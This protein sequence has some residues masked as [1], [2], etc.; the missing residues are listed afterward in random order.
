MLRSKMHRWRV[1]SLAVA[2]SCL[3]AANLA[4]QRRQRSFSL[5]ADSPEFW[6][7][8]A[9]DAQLVT[10]GS[11]FGFTEGPIWEPGGTLIVS[12]EV[13]NELCR[14][15]PD[16]HHETIMKLGDPDGNTL[17]QQRRVIV[18]ASVLRSLIRLSP[19]EKSYT[20]I[21]DRYQ[22]MRLN[23]PNDVTLGP[24][25][26]LYFTDP[27]LDL[28]KGEKQET[29]WKGVY[30]LASDGTLTLLVRDLSQPNGLA[31]SPDG[32]YLFVDD[33]ERK[34]I[35]RYTFHKEG[36]V[37]DGVLFAEEK[38]TDAPGVPDG[39]KFDRKGNLY[40]TGPG[41]I[42]VWSPEGKRLGRILLPT[43]AANLTWGGEDRSTM[44]ITAG[45]KVYTLKM[46]VAGYLPYAE[47]KEKK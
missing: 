46:K 36:T 7:L 2:L 20:V 8:V 18:T 37:S 3:A 24:D 17:D 43:T 39:M 47:P 42:W 34:E 9:K 10:V 25:G 38:S 6:S 21:A 5:E 26:A 19:D 30:R 12:D 23:S 16:G 11:G 14:L 35:W 28:V 45:P 32:R 15:Y 33:T 4:A 1:V 13:T 31:F 27:T 44:W 22:G 40:V 29:P 41:G